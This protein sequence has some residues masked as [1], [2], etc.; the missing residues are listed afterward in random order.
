MSGC[1]SPLPVYLHGV[2]KYF[3]FYET[4]GCHGCGYSNY[5]IPGVTPCKLVDT[6]TS[7]E[8]VASIFRVF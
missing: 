8:L 4:C 3:T 2:E 6:N 5:E 1:V 7:E